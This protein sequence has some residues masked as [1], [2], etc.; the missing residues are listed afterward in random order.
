MDPKPQPQD[1]ESLKKA[2]ETA[3]AMKFDTPKQFDKLRLFIF[4]RT[5]EYISRTTLMR[6]WGYINEPLN[7]RQSTFSLLARAVGYND[8]HEF[9]NRKLD[10]S[11]PEISSSYKFGRNIN[12]ISDLKPDQKVILYWEPARE[13]KTRYLGNMLFEV[14][15]SCNTRLMPGD[16]FYCNLIIPGHPLHLSGVTRGNSKPVSYICGCAHGGIQYE[17]VD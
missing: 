16:R 3:A 8:W 12:V 15:E 4:N 10:D 9:I 11:E 13:C 17:I 2:L 14:I 7:T 6:I 1:I 5:G